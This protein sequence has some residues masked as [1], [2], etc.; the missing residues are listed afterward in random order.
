[1]TKARKCGNL[2]KLSARAAPATEEAADERTKEF[3]KTRKKFLTKR[4]RC[5]RIKTRRLERR[6]PC[7]LNNVTNEK[8]QIRIWLFNKLS[9]SDDRNISLKLELSFDKVI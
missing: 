1:M 6:V 3:E 4:T 5:G 9:L 7:K 2:I 8:H